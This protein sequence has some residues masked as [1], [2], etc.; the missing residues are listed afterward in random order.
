MARAEKKLETEPEVYIS[1]GSQGLAL[2]TSI[3][4]EPLDA[5]G[6]DKEDRF[7]TKNAKIFNRA[8]G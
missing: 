2:D 4:M 3:M 8:I 5:K 6:T 1:E 7:G